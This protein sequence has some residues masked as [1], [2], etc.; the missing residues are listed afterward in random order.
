[1]IRQ[2]SRAILAAACLLGVLLGGCTDRA[3]LA[4]PAM[5]L[6]GPYR[7]GT[8]DRLRVVVYDQPT[9]T[10]VYEVDQSGDVSLPLIGDVGARDLTTDELGRTIRTKL[11]STYLRD[12]D[13][14][15]EVA[16]YRP[17][18]VLGEVGTPGQ[19]PYV[20]GITAETAVA[21]AGGF[22]D[23]ANKRVVRVSR[24]SHGKLYESR[25]PVIT[26]I[27][28]GDTIYVPESLF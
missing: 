6:S 28:P 23:R 25:M 3:P 22:T 11:A 10:N 16:T 5:A 27:R 8:G 12:P 15:V 1:M 24:T 4:E 20:P 21:V 19:Y 17:F 9:L 13:V 2:R 18:F 14:T 26:P 7:L